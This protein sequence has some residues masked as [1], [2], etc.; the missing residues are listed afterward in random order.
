MAILSESLS[1]FSE[2]VQNLQIKS[3][4]FP[5]FLLQSTS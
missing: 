5:F 4:N 1:E 2:S 3:T